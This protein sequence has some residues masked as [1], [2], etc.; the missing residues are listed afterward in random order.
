MQHKMCNIPRFQNSEK[1]LRKY[2]RNWMKRKATLLFSP[3]RSRRSK[4]SRRRAP[5]CPHHVVAWVHPPAHRHVVWGPRASTDVA[6]SPINTSQE[7]TLGTRSQFHEKFHRCHRHQ[8]K[9]G[10]VLKLF[11]APCRRGDH[12]RR[13]LHHHACL[14]SDA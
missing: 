10:R 2:S 4:E 3:T 9:I 7:K 5:M 14:R 1:L 12:H 11:P 6:P 8:P 13:A